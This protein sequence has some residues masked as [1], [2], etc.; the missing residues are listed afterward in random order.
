[1]CLAQ[2][3]NAVTLVRLEPATL[4]LETI[5]AIYHQAP[6]HRHTLQ[7]LPNSIKVIDSFH[8]VCSESDILLA[9]FIV[10]VQKVTFY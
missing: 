10:F 3:H 4:D 8:S 2:G 7:F 1:M 5:Q 9:L 6:Y